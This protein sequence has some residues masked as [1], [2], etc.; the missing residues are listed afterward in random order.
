MIKLQSTFN[1]GSIQQLEGKDIMAIPFH[2]H[3]LYKS[4]ELSLTNSDDESLKAI[5]LKPLYMQVTPQFIL[6]N[7]DLYCYTTNHSYAN[8]RR[9]YL[10]ALNAIMSTNERD[11]V[12]STNRF[13]LKEPSWDMI[14][15]GFAEILIIYKDEII[16]K[17][18]E[19][20]V[21][22]TVLKENPNL[23]YDLKELLGRDIVMSKLTKEEMVR[24]ERIPYIFYLDQKNY[25]RCY[26]KITAVEILKNNLAYLI[27]DYNRMNDPDN[28]TLDDMRD[29]INYNANIYFEYKYNHYLKGV[30]SQDAWHLIRSIILSKIAVYNYFIKLYEIS[31]N[32]LDAL[33]QLFEMIGMKNPFVNGSECLNKKTGN[34]LIDSEEECNQASLIDSYL[35]IVVMVLGF[36]KIESQVKRMITTSKVNIYQEFFN[37]LIMDFDIYQLPKIVFD[38][39]K[40]KFKKVTPNKFILSREEREYQK[41]VE[42]IKRKVLYKERGKYFI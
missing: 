21:I 2:E 9:E 14:Q 37:Y 13:S 15:R 30:Y 16:L 19:G 8:F 1:Y 25:R 39:K 28:V 33:S 6:P 4:V 27:S 11:Y 18:F 40:N 7:G 3:T 12:L 32:P 31:N 20:S 23:Y 26:M 29:Y 5:G 35:D 34:P 42:L 38:E 41:E 10:I 36:D 17:E 22:R 24:N